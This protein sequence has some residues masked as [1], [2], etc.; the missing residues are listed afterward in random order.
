MPTT[1]EFGLSLDPW[2]RLILIDAE[3][4]RYVGV[5]PVRSFPVSDPSRGISLCDGQ[6]H[7]V[8]WVE[9]LSALPISTRE[10][11]AS[12]LARR[13]FSP[14]IQRILSVSS[15]NTPSQWK[16]VTDRGP[17]QFTLDNEDDVRRL[18]HERVLITDARGIRYQVPDTRKLDTPS[19]R[20][21]ERYL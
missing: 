9:D 2:G 5:E 14:V 7:E 10:L 15:D 8:V 16:V 11:L 13:E 1:P 17:T 20:L 18:G 4:K 19:R 3:G 21:L 6:G 12:E